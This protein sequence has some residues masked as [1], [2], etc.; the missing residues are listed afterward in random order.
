MK[1]IFTVCMLFASMMMSANE[2]VCEGFVKRANNGN[3][4]YGEVFTWTSKQSNTMQL[5]KFEAGTL[6]QYTNLKLALSN[7][8]DLKG[9]ASGNK[10]RVLFLAEGTT[11]KTISMATIYSSGTTSKD[12]VLLEQM[13]AEQIAH[14]ALLIAS[15][16][17][18]FTNN[19]IIVEKV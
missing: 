10:V 13:T 18:V 11:I 12:F 4:S 5:F 16:I 9:T 14:E 2:W 3:C 8:V 19:N 7:F 1:K 6:S 15:E 17:C